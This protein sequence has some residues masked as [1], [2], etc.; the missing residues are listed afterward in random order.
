MSNIN[1][2]GRVMT[3]LLA[4]R[5]WLAPLLICVVCALQGCDNRP[6]PSPTPNPHPQRT[7][8]LKITVEK[9]SEVNRVEVKSEW[10]VGNLSCAPVIWPA[11]YERVKQ[12][13]ILEKA[14]KQDDV[15]IATIVLDRFV[16]D[17]CRWV[18]GG[19][20]IR[21]YRNS[22]WISTDGVN[23]DVL[24]GQSVQKMTCLTRP[25]DPAGTCGLRDEETWYKSEDKNA[26]NVSVELMK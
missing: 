4:W 15:Y 24:Q 2:E 20:A 10:V 7:S 22:D 11:G 9:G 12:V 13:D 17:K 19:V 6:A 8:K 1:S 18:L 21:F 26:F 25:F 14:Q 16:R 23:S 5:R 3:H